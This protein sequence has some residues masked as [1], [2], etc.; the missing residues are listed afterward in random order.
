MSADLYRIK[1]EHMFSLTK[2]EERFIRRYFPQADA[3]TFYVNG[4]EL[5]GIV[6]DAEDNGEETPKELIE[7]FRDEIRNGRELYFSLIGGQK[8]ENSTS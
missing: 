6:A 1:Y 7:N 4:A 5:E 2:E 8:N 3:T